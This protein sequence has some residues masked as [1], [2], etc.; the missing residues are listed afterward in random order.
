MEEIAN[1][2]VD[3]DVPGPAGGFVAA[4][5]DVTGKKLVGG[6]QATDAAHMSVAIAADFVADAFQCHQAA[7]I[8]LE[9]REDALEFKIGADFIRPELRR[10][11]AV[12]RE[13]EN[14]ALVFCAGSRGCHGWQRGQE[15]QGS[16]GESELAEKL[17]AR[18]EV[19]FG[20]G[21]G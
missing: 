10:D 16:G 9:R 4:A 17:A 18:A 14:D 7:F 20:I 6:E 8:W 12:G 15:R 1:F 5:L 13:E 2:L 11:G 3:R 21:L 19:H